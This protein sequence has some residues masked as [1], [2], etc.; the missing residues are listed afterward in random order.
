MGKLD[1][2]QL[3]LPRLEEA[4]V[5]AVAQRGVVDVH[6]VVRRA[7]PREPGFVG[8]HHLNFLLS[9]LGFFFFLP[10]LLG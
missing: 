3:A 10:A 5:V 4:A 2:I 7:A 9:F 8:Y 6:R 1:W